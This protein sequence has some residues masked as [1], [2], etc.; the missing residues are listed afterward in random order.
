M[1]EFLWLD[2]HMVRLLLGSGR[3]VLTHWS[4]LDEDIWGEGGFKEICSDF[5]SLSANN[6]YLLPIPLCPAQTTS[7]TPYTYKCQNGQ[8]INKVNPECDSVKDCPDGSDE[9][10]ATCSK[11]T[12]LPGKKNLKTLL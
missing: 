6:D 7:C 3:C 9:A 11:W 5:M 4:H 12:H 8:C 2:I 1:K 10:E